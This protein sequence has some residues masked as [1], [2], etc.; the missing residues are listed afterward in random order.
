[1][2]IT[3]MTPVSV[4]VAMPTDQNTYLFLDSSGIAPAMYVDPEDREF[5]LALGYDIWLRPKELFDALRPYSPIIEVD[6]TEHHSLVESE[7]S[8]D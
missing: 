7:A 2:E 4:V 3:G 6:L 1:M 8:H 5:A